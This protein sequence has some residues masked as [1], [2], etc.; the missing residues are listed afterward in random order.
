M[1]MSFSKIEVGNLIGLLELDVQSDILLSIRRS[2]AS[3]EQEEQQDRI[4]KI[5]DDASIK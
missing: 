4:N 2:L 3:A 5:K 1:A